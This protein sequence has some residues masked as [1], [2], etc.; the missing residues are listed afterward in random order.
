M[1]RGEKTEELE[2]NKAVLSVTSKMKLK[3]WAWAQTK[4]LDPG[5]G[6]MS[7]FGLFGGKCV[8]WSES[9]VCSTSTGKMHGWDF[10]KGGIGQ[11]VWLVNQTAALD[12]GAGS[13]SAYCLFESQGQ[14]TWV[15]GLA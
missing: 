9:S 15:C 2:S 10:L 8:D 5:K 13:W 12:P 7:K 1:V 3:F 6:A 11:P 4:A 14:A